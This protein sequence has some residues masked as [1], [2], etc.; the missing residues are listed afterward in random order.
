MRASGSV[1]YC[2]MGDRYLAC[3]LGASLHFQLT[4]LSVYRCSVALG[5]DIR[6]VG[7][8][9]RKAQ[10]PSPSLNSHVQPK[11]I[12]A[13]A[14]PCAL[15]DEIRLCASEGIMYAGCI[16]WPADIASKAH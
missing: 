16:S 8:F 11:V 15:S 3:V 10:R 12:C 9:A 6:N 2:L 5:S 1:L 13:R 4:L 14:F 7:G